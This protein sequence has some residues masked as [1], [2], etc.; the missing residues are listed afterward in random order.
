MRVVATMAGL[1]IVA[2][3]IRMPHF[4]NPAIA[5]D[6]Q[7]YL[8][9]GDRMLHGAVPYVDIW[10]RKP[11]G[12]FLIYAGVRLLGGTGIIQ[13]QI[14]A[15]LF[16]AA[17]AAC[18]VALARRATSPPASI[19]V[20]VLYLLWIEIAE[21][22]GGQSPV[23]YNLFVAGAAY[24]TLSAMEAPG[25]SQ[26]RRLA[27]IA[28]TLVGLAIQVKYTVLPEGLF[29]G[30]TCSW[31]LL[32]RSGVN[33]RG[34]VEVGALAAV[35][36]APTMLVVAGYAWFGHL[37][38]FWF[39]NFSSIFL[40][41][42]TDPDVLQFRIAVA[43]VRSAP[44]GLCALVAA[45]HLWRDVDPATRRWQWF[46]LGWLVF[47]MAGFLMLGVLYTHYLLPVFVPLTVAAAPAFTRRPLGLLLGCFA[48]WLPASH[49]RYPDFATTAKSQ[50]EVAALAALIPASASTGCLHMFDGPP[51]LYHLT[52][53]CMASRYAFPDHLSAS[54]E[55]HAIGVD[56]VNEVKA[57]LARR[58]AVITL[59]R[60]DIRP[61][62]HATF[63][64]MWTGLARSYLLAGRTEVDG[65]PIEVWVRR[66]L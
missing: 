64:V 27:F 57:L 15:T 37:K 11:I 31:V 40:R 23:F 61:P 34:L 17:T 53:A 13:Y 63:A 12:L 65:R 52:N 56:P 39:A 59:S 46:M 36:L 51:I 1:L 26:A 47:A 55:S 43:L 3:M 5:P 9:V 16:A 21:G 60:I 7:F 28:M 24:L 20:G 18:I 49:L 22:G 8:L 4:G 10:D 41:G 32:R 50:R 66:G 25:Q 54:I 44:L 29:L 30:L 6:E 45:S 48:A 42:E 2:L 58:P 19:F 33:I 62:N 35:T 14:V 38:P